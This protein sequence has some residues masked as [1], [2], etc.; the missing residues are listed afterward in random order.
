MPETCGCEAPPRRHCDLCYAE[1]RVLLACSQACLDRHQLTHGALL[2]AVARAK[3]L[4]AQMNARHRDSSV[5]FASHRARL[6]QLVDAAGVGERLLVLGVGNGS[7]LDVPFLCERFA[8]V[9]LVD[10]DGA[11]LERVKARQPLSV[12]ERLVLHPD[13]DLS[14]VLEHLD[15][16]GDAFPE[17]WELGRRAVAAARRLVSELGS[18]DVT[19]STCVLS[20]L[21]LPFRRSWVAPVSTWANLSA[22]ITAVH[23]ATLAGCTLRSGI[24]AFDV[25][26]TDGQ[27]SPEPSSLVAHL[28]SPGLA[29][30]V[31]NPTLS[32]PWRWDLG[33]V[34]QLVYAI[35]FR[36][37]SGRAAVTP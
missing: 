24:L 32:E 31:E 19:L 9:H 13:V 4:L 18:F 23:L 1:G 11:A 16:W 25:Q 34:E 3:L 36:R 27:L 6:M 12:Q 26:S 14:G 21:A 2:S 8:A 30:L 28:R 22:A 37:P 10:L 20:Q 35:E 33:D 17:P 29:A 7:D 15:T 5:S